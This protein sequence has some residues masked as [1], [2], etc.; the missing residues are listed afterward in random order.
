MVLSAIKS[1][2]AMGAVCDSHYC[3]SFGPTKILELDWNIKFGN[4]LLD[5]YLTLIYSRI[6]ECLNRRYSPYPHLALTPYQHFKPVM[7]SFMVVPGHVLLFLG[8]H[9]NIRVSFLVVSFGND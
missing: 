9:N 6:T 1:S 3:S 5:F 8:R 2:H 4:V 7:D